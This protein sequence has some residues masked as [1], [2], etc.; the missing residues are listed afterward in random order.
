MG[1]LSSVANLILLLFGAQNSAK[2]ILS[3]IF[4]YFILLTGIIFS[5][6][7]RRNSS[8]YQIERLDNFSKVMFMF[9]FISLGSLPPLLGFLGKLLILKT[10]ILTVRLP[11]IILLVF[12]SLIILYTYISRFFFLFKYN[13]IYK[14]KPKNK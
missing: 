14:I 4:I 6:N 9:I 2:L 1:A 8:L 5:I 12:T 3:F 11:A 7:I 10:I 13:T